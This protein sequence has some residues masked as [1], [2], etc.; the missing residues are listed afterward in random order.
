MNMAVI[1][2]PLSEMATLVS[3]IAIGLF[4]ARAFGRSA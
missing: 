1:A 4:I 2:W 3:G